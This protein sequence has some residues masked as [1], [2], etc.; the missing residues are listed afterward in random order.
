MYDERDTKLIERIRKA[1][2]AWVN[3]AFETND[4]VIGEIAEDNE[5]YE[6]EEEA[7]RY[8]VDVAVRSIGHWLLIEAWVQDEEVLSISNLGE[9]IPLN[10]PAWPW[11]EGVG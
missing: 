8:L 10:D 6:G 5:D 11:A 1:V 2:A 9:G 7:V 4:I 3:D